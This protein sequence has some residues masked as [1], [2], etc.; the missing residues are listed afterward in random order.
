MAIIPEHLV[1]FFF[2]VSCVLVDRYINI[3]LDIV[4]HSLPKETIPV[5]G[6]SQS[7]GGSTRGH[8][9]AILQ[10]LE[11]FGVTLITQMVNQQK[12]RSTCIYLTLTLQSL[13]FSSHPLS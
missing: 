12:E 1:K 5:H 13:I 3:M 10:M 9:I 11:R 7:M 8:A 6:S 2:F 4:M